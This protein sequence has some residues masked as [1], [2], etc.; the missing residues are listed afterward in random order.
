MLISL[1]LAKTTRNG[2][3]EKEETKSCGITTDPLRSKCV[4]LKSDSRPNLT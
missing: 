3:L 1:T 4:G 2:T